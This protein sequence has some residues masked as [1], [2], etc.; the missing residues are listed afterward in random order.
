MTQRKKSRKKGRG[1]VL[2]VLSVGVC[3]LAMSI[4]MIAYLD[5]MKLITTKAQISQLTR[6]YIL[7]ME[8]VGYLTSSDQTELIMDLLELGIEDITLEGTT[9][10]EVAYGS[11]ILL[12][13]EG[14]ILGKE[15]SSQQGIFA[16]VFTPRKYSFQEIK[17]STA[18]N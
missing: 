16:T 17:M 13:I 4:M 5:N 7:R 8:T 9:M 12:C 15:T 6:K 2:D 10:Q 1:S 11:P 18:K 3:I 14:T